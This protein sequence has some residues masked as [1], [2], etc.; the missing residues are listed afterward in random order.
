M[1]LIL[2]LLITG[3]SGL[4]PFCCY[5]CNKKFLL[6]EDGIKHTTDFHENLMLK[7]R[8]LELNSASGKL[9]Y[10][11]HNFNV[12]PTDEKAKGQTIIAEHS[13]TQLSVRLVNSTDQNAFEQTISSPLSKKMRTNTVDTKVDKDQSFKHD[14]GLGSVNTKLC[15]YRDSKSKLTYEDMNSIIS[16]MPSVADYLK[17]PGRWEI[18]KKKSL[19]VGFAQ[20]PTE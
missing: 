14:I 3:D 7:I 16:V 10:R 9:G 1:I 20:I 13:S 2:I 5:Y 15:P 11:C 19:F 4:S 17:S 6:L 12:I 18:W 8:S